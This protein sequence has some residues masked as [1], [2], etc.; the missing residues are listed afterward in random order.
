MIMELRAIGGIKFGR[1][2]PKYLGKPI[3]S[4]LSELFV[5]SEIKL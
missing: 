4:P 3:L 5:I 2:K 1:G